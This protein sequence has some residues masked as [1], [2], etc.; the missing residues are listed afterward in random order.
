VVDTNCSPEGV[1][2]M[3]PGNDDAIRSIRLYT[4]IAAESVLEGRASAPVVESNEEFVELDADG[5]PIKAKADKPKVDARKP[6]KKKVAN[7]VVARQSISAAAADELDEAEASEPAEAEASADAE[8][9]VELTEAVEV[10]PAAKKKVSK[11]KAVTKSED[12]E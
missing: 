1:D 8:V 2:Y 3:I 6:A 10:K 11:K 12:A 9:A 7:K 5:N 4:Q